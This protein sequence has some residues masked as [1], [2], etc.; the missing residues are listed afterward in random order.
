MIQT[1]T[2]TLRGT[3]MGKHKEGK[4]QTERQTEGHRKR[5]DS[6]M[7]GCPHLFDCVCG[8]KREE[9]SGRNK[10]INM[11][12][13]PGNAGFLDNSGH[14]QTN[15]PFHNNSKQTQMSPLLAPRHWQKG[16]SLPGALEG[17]KDV[18]YS[19]FLSY[20]KFDLCAPYFMCAKTCRRLIWMRKYNYQRN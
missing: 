8:Q 11:N 3:Q 15:G 10:T 12:S 16:A 14:S 19:K 2:E 18:I 17:K 20:I 4:E 13:T 7:R 9:E 1:R 6:N 5:E